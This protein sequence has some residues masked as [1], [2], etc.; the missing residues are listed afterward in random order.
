MRARNRLGVAMLLGASALVAGAAVA[1]EP[2]SAGDCF[3][4]A[5][6]AADADAVSMCY[7]EDG[8]IWFPGGP[9]AKGRTA[10][11]DGFAHFLASNII[12]DVQLD[13]IGQEAMGDTRVAWGTYAIT[14]EDKVSHA[15]SIE[16]G[17]YTEVQKL[18]DG[19]WLYIVDHPSDDP[20]PAAK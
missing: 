4:A 15:V 13:D 8:I 17:R 19:R 5:M 6:K 1:A 3:I 18:I 20:P 14:M 16:R 2:A 12:K 9:M 10:I 11:R 7:A